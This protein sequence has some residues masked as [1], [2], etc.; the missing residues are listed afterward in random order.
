[1]ALQTVF[2]AGLT[3]VY[4]LWIS[5]AD[6]FDSTTSN[7]IHDCSIV[8]FVIA[9]R[10]PAAKRYRNAFELIRQ[11]VIDRIS[12]APPAERRSR[13]TVPGL[14]ADL[15][16]SAS[17]PFEAAAGYTEAGHF[18]VDERSLEQVSHILT[19]MAGE[20]GSQEN[21]RGQRGMFT[22]EFAGGNYHRTTQGYSN[23]DNRFPESSGV[24]VHGNCHRA[25]TVNGPWYQEF[26]F[27]PPF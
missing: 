23:P 16:A 7:G 13:E 6:I 18:G 10:V 14:T 12:T 2:M 11:R 20:Q 24:D 19:E 1:M 9:D 27:A 26:G 22:A 4:C 21:N 15:A 8:L 25:S 5:P 3:L 17:N